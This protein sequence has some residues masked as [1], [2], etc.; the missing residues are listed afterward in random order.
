LDEY[1]RALMA[2]QS[3]LEIERPR[4]APELIGA[5]FALYRRYPWLFLIL[6]AVVVVPY[7]AVEALPR[8]E[9]LDGPAK[10]WLDFALTIGDLALVLPLV[11]AL[12]VFA[13]TD[14]REGRQP[15][16][17]SAARRGI[18]T[19]GETTESGQDGEGRADQKGGKR[20]RLQPED[21]DQGDVRHQR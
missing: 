11:S 5:T 1:I 14:V 19:A 17:S 15:L 16:V 21:R 10:G 9:L 20:G 7:Q 8:L 2:G 4:S 6:A 3:E 13:V 12:H 18:G